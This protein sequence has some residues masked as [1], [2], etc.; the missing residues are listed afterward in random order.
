MKI[1]TPILKSVTPPTSLDD[2]SIRHFF[3]DDGVDDP[4]DSPKPIIVELLNRVEVFRRNGCRYRKTPSSEDHCLS[5]HPNLR[6]NE[7]KLGPGGTS[8]EIQDK[9]S[10]STVSE[11]LV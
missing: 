4:H 7:P 1:W 8:G 10:T 5:P 2:W 9:K 6:V 11:S 3:P